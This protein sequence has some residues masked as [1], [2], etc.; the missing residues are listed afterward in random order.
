[1]I[2]VEF[3]FDVYS[4]NEFKRSGHTLSMKMNIISIYDMYLNQGGLGIGVDFY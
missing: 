2:H 1:M 3:V 4:F